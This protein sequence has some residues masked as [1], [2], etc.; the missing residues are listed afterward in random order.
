MIPL[1]IL[2]IRRYILRRRNVPDG[3]F[4]EALR[5]ENSGHFE[6]ALISYKRALSEANKKG[7]QGSSFKTKI[8][9]KLKI[10]N[11]VIAYKNGFQPGR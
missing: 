10:L 5:N 2:F 6:A 7:F 9:E 1:L 11:T 3:L 4:Y 8:I